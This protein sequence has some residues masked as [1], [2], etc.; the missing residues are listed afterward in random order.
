MADKVM[1]EME[2][3]LAAVPGASPQLTELVGT[4][5]A[6]VMFASLLVVVV[7][8]MTASYHLKL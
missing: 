3:L 7:L 2:G 5:K 1:A 8:L 6:I 4:I